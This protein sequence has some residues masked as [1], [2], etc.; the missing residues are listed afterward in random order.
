MHKRSIL[1]A[2]FVAGIVGSL[3]FV[4]RADEGKE[5]KIQFSQAPEAVQKTLTR[6]AEGNAIQT[7]DKEMKHDK[8]IYE[9]DVKIDGK[10]YE[11]KVAEDGTLLVKKLDVEE[12]HHKGK[13]EGKDEDKDND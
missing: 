2:L 12:H 8:T 10:N 3:A 13:H 11:I 9:A 5:Q 7:V 6:E 1:I 4:A